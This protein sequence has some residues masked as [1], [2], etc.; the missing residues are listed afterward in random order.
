[1]KKP[2]KSPKTRKRLFGRPSK[3]T[4]DPGV[5]PKKKDLRRAA[6]RWIKSHPKAMALF[7]KFA[8]EMVFQKRKFGIGLLTERVRWQYKIE[9]KR[10]ND[11][12][13]NNSFRAYFSRWLIAKEPQIEEYMEFRAVSY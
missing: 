2:M 8:L 3:I 5:F 11:Y 10:A 13:I 4:V 1:M 12:K 6:A 9:G 7:L